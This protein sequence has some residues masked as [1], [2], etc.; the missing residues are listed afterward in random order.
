MLIRY[1]ERYSPIFRIIAIAIICVFTYSG[2]AFALAPEL[3]LTQQAFSEQYLLRSILLSHRSVN[4]YISSYINPNAENNIDLTKLAQ[5]RLDRI[6][7]QDGSDRSPQEIY[8]V[9]IKYLLKNTGQLAHIG[10]GNKNGNPV[11]YIDSKY[12]YDEDLLWHEK[13][14]IAQ[15]ENL[16]IQKDLS[17]HEMRDW[18]IKYADTP[19][20]AEGLNTRQIAEKF[21]SSS[22]NIDHI[23]KD[24]KKR[25]TTFIEAARTEEARSLLDLGKIFEFYSDT[26]YVSD[27]H[28]RDI[29]I[30]ASDNGYGSDR[31]FSESWI[32]KNIPELKGKTVLS[33]SMEGNIPEF[34]GYEARSANTKGGLGAYFGDKLEGMA[35]IGINALGAQIGYSHVR[36]DGRKIKVSYDELINNGVMEKVFT[37]GNAIKVR[38]WDEDP[39][40]RT[41]DKEDRYNPETKVEVYKINRGGATDYI[42][43]SKVFDELYSDDRAHRFTQEIVFGKAVYV[44]MKKMGLKPD[45]LHLNEAHTVVAAAQMR[46]DESFNNT[47]IV[48]TNHTLVRAGLEIFYPASV[49]SNVDR[50]M[51]VIGLP[52]GK[53]AKFRSIFLRPD[54]TVDFCYA[55]MKLADVINAVSDEHAKATEMLFRNLY[56][57][58]FDKPVVGV[59]NGSGQTWKS[60]KLIELELSGRKP[61]ALDAWA[62]HES[63]KAE[64]I[65]EI[66]KKTGIK[67]DPDKPTAWAVRR[68]VEYKSQYPALKFIIHLMTADK[69]KTFT[70][71]ELKEIWFRDIT[72]FKQDYDKNYLAA[73]DITESVLNKIFP[74][75]IDRVNG[76]GMQVV[77]GWPAPAYQEF[78][79]AEFYKWMDLPDLKGKFVAVVSD[80]EIL[81]MQ[82]IGADV[83]IT[84]PKPLEEAC[85][86]SDQRTGLNFGVNIAIKG[87]GPVEWIEEYD[88]KSESG[89]GFFTGS[90]TKETAG[91]LE[92]DNEKFYK[93]MPADIFEKAALCS[94]LFY[95]DGKTKWKRLMLNAYLAANETVTAVAMEKRYALDVY[96]AALRSKN[97]VE[98]AAIGKGSPADLLETIKSNDL[99]MND[100]I[101]KDRGISVRDAANLRGYSIR[102]VQREFKVLRD[103]GI[104]IQVAP[105][106]ARMR[107][108]D[109]MLGRDRDEGYTKSLINA[110]INIKYRVGKRGEE[111]PLRRASIP[112]DIIATLGE[113]VRMTVINEMEKEF[114]VPEGKTLYH[115]IEQDVIPVGQRS[116]LVQTANNVFYRD[117]KG[118]ER[119]LILNAKQNVSDAIADIRTKDPGALI[120]VAL[121]D[122][123]HIVDVRDEGVKKMVFK[124]E[125][126]FID[127]N[128]VLKALRTLH[129]EDAKET[130]S[131][132]LRLYAV[133]AGL[134]PKGSLPAISGVYVFNLP[135]ISRE[136]I[137]NIPKL[138]GHLIQLLTAA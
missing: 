13:N 36:K 108:S 100:A 47:A 125:S 10:L 4:K 87:A 97:V 20:P 41:D 31:K 28:L 42:F 18:I 80:P 30:A 29:N 23:Y 75:G 64:A 67:L 16:R 27:N 89:S 15:W 46:A 35:A 14:E 133:M 9:G 37:D 127:L 117:N 73:R 19:D 105:G 12:F 95:E 45:M 3:R 126:D 84:M 49:R 61:D 33:L 103:L 102:T 6:L 118:P 113:L 24:I 88:E 124:T 40:A 79:A 70:R 44:F 91:G 121:S 122:E 48:Y 39:E 26:G 110:I 135:K 107:F 92:A 71:A 132:L 51:Y 83:C 129:Y 134:P 7:P 119:I 59:L 90:Y 101:N 136:D 94:R 81:K 123:S 1:K 138:N 50:M 130:L 78:W 69:T 85:G 106:S 66:E 77:V 32:E 86:T 137:N 34:A 63:G 5:F 56:G 98:L 112:N 99:L 93:E 55:A 21:H 68:L 58:E 25:Y 11:I 82:A 104:L 43:M 17:Y 131:A 120:D 109:M 57:S 128:G 60:D 76:L 116:T 65:K 8:V 62:I 115:I 52:A 54:G 53:A 38:A 72:N 2:N 111:R 96:T 114:V 22:N 74:S